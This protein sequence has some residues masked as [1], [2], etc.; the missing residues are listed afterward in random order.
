MFEGLLPEICKRDET[1]IWPFAICTPVDNKVLLFGPCLASR[2]EGIPHWIP[3]LL[4][5]RS[6]SCSRALEMGMSHVILEKCG[7]S[8]A[9]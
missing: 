1:R 2:A 6:P 5:W 7:L 4:A 3:F 8:P 9:L